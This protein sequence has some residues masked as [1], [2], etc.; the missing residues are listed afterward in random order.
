M[1]STGGNPNEL[2]GNDR[3]D[4]ATRLGVPAGFTNFRASNF[5]GRHTIMH[6]T[7]TD[8]R[9][10]KHRR[11]LDGSFK[12]L[13][14]MTKATVEQE[15]SKNRPTVQPNFRRSFIRLWSVS[16][17]HEAWMEST[18]LRCSISKDDDDVQQ[19]HI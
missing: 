1:I 5:L 3:Q 18:V 10:A 17:R 6:F 7:P 13:T 12:P 19:C 11:R 14:L 9:L 16:P 4:L 2:T 8:P 15:H